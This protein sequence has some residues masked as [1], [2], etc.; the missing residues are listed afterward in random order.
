GILVG[1][2]G[3]GVLGA[4]VVHAAL[5]HPRGGVWLAGDLPLPERLVHAG[6]RHVVPLGLLGEVHRRH[7]VVAHVAREV[8]GQDAEDHERPEH[9]QERDAALAVARQVSPHHSSSP[10]SSPLSVSWDSPPLPDCCPFP[11]CWPSAPFSGSP[12]SLA[13][14]PPSVSVETMMGISWPQLSTSSPGSASTVMRM[15]LGRIS[16]SRASHDERHSVS[17]PTSSRYWKW[18]VRKPS[19]TAVV[20]SPARSS[21][22]RPRPSDEND[23]LSVSIR[24]GGFGQ[25]WSPASFS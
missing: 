17:L 8:E 16:S 2:A 21:R 19:S 13:S 24:Q 25:A 5:A 6:E 15:A 1:H 23:G 12:S 14:A 9:E 7:G 11:T 18:S 3:A 10:S 20:R 4:R 22:S